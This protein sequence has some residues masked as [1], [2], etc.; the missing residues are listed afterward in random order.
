MGIEIARFLQRT[1]AYRNDNLHEFQYHIITAA[2]DAALESEEKNRNYIFIM[3]PERL[4]YLLI[5]EKDIHLDYLFIDEAH[6]LSGADKRSTFYYQFVHMLSDREDKPR[7]FFASPN[8]P[9]PEIYLKL[10]SDVDTETL[11][12]NRMSSRFSPVSQEKFL[13][14][15][16]GKEVSVYNEHTKEAIPLTSIAIED[17]G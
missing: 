4:L 6:K 15:L 10:I 2:G 14:N 16:V 12:D 3:T 9:N 11:L 13:I 5:N 17:V 1:Y 7:I 8:V